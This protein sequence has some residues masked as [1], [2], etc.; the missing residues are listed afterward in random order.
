MTSMGRLLRNAIPGMVF[1]VLNRANGRI[2]IFAGSGDYQAFE[3]I[4]EPARERFPV[5]YSPRFLGQEV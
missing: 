5:L 4:L 3:A 2:R 1:H